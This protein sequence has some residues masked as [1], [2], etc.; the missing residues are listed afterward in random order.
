MRGKEAEIER[1]AQEEV[2]ITMMTSWTRK[3]NVEEKRKASSALDQ[4]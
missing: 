4:Q 3:L 1:Y 2:T